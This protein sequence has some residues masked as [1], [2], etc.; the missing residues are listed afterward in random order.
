MSDHNSE[1]KSFESLKVWQQARNIRNEI[2]Q[3]S[4]S[5]PKEETYKLSDQMIRSSRSMEIIFLRDTVDII[6]R[7]T[8]NFADNQEVQ[9]TNLLIT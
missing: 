4:R 8:F 7:K 6:I 9:P 5:F 1:F 3:I 2:F